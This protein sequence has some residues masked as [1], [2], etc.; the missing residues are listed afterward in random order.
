MSEESGTGGPQGGV[1]KPV[2]GVWALLTAVGS[3]IVLLPP[4]YA[5]GDIE[6]VAVLTAV[7]AFIFVF[8]VA[9]VQ[10]SRRIWEGHNAE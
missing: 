3:T 5:S 9:K 10:E 8:G 7:T 4:V 6:T 1:Y 2:L